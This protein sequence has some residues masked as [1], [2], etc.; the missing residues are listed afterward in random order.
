MIRRGLVR[1]VTG[2]LAAAVLLAACAGCG[3]GKKSPADGGGDKAEAK[4]DLGGRTVTLGSWGS[5]APDD[6]DPHYAEWMDLIGGIEEKYN[7]KLDFYTTNDFHTYNTAI[8]TTALSGDI[9][10]DAFWAHF[11]TMVPR[12]VNQDLVA[13]L[14]DYFDFSLDMWNANEND[15]W[16]MNGKHYGITNWIDEPGHMILFNKKI[17][18]DN[19]ISPES[20]Y[21]LQNDGSW[22]WDKLSEYAIKC[23]RDTNND[24][25]ID[26]WGFGS[27]SASPYTAE[28]FIYA[29]GSAPVTLTEDFKYTYNL[30]DPR[31]VEAMEFGH[32]LCY[33][34]KVCDMSS[35]DV[36]YWE[37]LW[38]R[39]KI[40]FYE[41]PSWAWAP[42]YDIFAEAGIEYGI[43]Y[44]PKGPQADDYVNPESAMGGIFMQPAV[45]DKEAIAAIVTEFEAPQPWK[46][47][48]DLRAKHEGRV[49]DDESLETIVGVKDRSVT[50]KGEVATWFR[51][52]VLWSDWGIKSN[53]PV[54]TFI[55]QN[56]APSQAAMDEIWNA[57]LTIPEDDEGE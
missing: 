6:S 17:V 57:K 34:D 45:K 18:S 11:Q 3:G 36:G 53:T 47:N 12:W 28:P 49:F 33:E 43:L 5:L 56:K 22:T 38:K 21:K 1:L 48:Y 37:A 14:D 27:Y 15:T 52:H 19:N 29:N 42:Y 25:T 8:L 55:A 4:Y 50:L 2:G 46:T 32:K 40:A 24:G 13:P 7:C 41:A 9:I 44:L 23:T 16:K 30:E 51:D 39:G 31:V 26:T 10:A 35:T 20:L 54:M